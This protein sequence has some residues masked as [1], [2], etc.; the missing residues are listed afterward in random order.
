MLLALPAAAGE[1]GL[2]GSTFSS[3]GAGLL[4]AGLNGSLCLGEQP[5]PHIPQ[6]KSAA[7]GLGVLSGE[8][9]FY[10][11]GCWGLFS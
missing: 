5:L 3:E 1:A 10:G 7:L 4:L 8:T 6:F 9:A 2:W 11:G